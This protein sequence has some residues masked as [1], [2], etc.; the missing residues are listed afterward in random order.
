MVYSGR[1]TEYGN[2]VEEQYNKVVACFSSQP[3]TGLDFQE[4]LALSLV[5]LFPCAQLPAQ[6]Q[7]QSKNS[8]E[9]GLAR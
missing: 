7:A 8:T 2:C 9:A 4:G 3:D 5:L 6:H 1:I